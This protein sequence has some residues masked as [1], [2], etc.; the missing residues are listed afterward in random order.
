MLNIRALAAIAIIA[1]VATISAS[2][3]AEPLEALADSFTPPAGYSFCSTDPKD[4]NACL[5]FC[6]PGGF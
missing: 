2:P 6:R 3:A 4:I 5:N 1:A